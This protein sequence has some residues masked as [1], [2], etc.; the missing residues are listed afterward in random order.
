MKRMLLLSLTLLL[1]ISV[2]FSQFGIKGGVNLGTIG[3]DD[4]PS[5][6]K[7]RMGIAGGI[8]Y[9]IGLIAGLSIQPEV[10]YIQKGSV[11]EVNSLQGMYTFNYKHTGKLDYIDIPVLLKFNLPVP[12]FSPY[13]E[14]GMS[15]GILLSAKEK[16][17]QS[18]NAPGITSE[19]QETDIKDYIT[20]NDLSWIVGVGFDL[21]I[22][23]INA[24]YVVGMKRL[25]KDDPATTSID[26]NAPK[27][28]NRGII[29]TAGFRF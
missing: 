15:Y 14:G 27:V 13:I 12:V 26:E 3:G 17:E 11:I 21:S 16:S 25:Y 4:K 19:S 1:C 9:R 2:A 6:L 22:L 10:M 5:D 28:Y 7:N 20:K 18:S 23:D 29:L 24:R 8:S